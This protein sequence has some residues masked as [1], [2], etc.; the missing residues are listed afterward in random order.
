MS[1]ACTVINTNTKICVIITSSATPRRD[2]PPIRVA[3]D[4]WN[5]RTNL[6][7]GFLLPELYGFKILQ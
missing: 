5:V 4:L 3:N 1:G 6:V 7:K 2:F